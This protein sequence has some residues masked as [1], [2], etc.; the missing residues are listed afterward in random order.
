M[1][2]VNNWLLLF[3]ILVVVQTDFFGQ[4][5]QFGPWEKLKSEYIKG[6]GWLFVYVDRLSQDTLFENYGI[7]QR[8]VKT[9]ENVEISRGSLTG[10]MWWNNQCGC[11]GGAHGL[12]INRYRN[13]NLKEIG[14]YYCERKKGTWTYY[15]ENGNLMKYETYDAPYLETLTEKGP[16]W[17][18]LKNTL[19]NY[20]YLLSGSYAEYYANGK[21]KEEGSYEIIEE[22][23][24]TDTVIIMA[25]ET[26]E[27]TKVAIEG[28]FW[29]PKSVKTG[30]WKWGDE[31]GNLIRVEDIKPLW[32][33]NTR[34]RPIASRY[35]E[36]FFE[37]KK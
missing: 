9:K 1:R 18:T 11:D 23:S 29:L 19:R 35:N 21:L 27:E 10:G 5:N 25:P 8:I 2:I 26:Y 4:E 13:G 3:G 24:E 6:Q 17:D 20:S 28:P 22:F 32:Y 37:K 12:W 7:G 14:E 34:Y 15:Y 33:D 16:P 30:I 31:N 36:L